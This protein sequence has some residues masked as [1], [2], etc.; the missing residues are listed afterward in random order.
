MSKKTVFLV[1]KLALAAAFGLA[2]AFTL[3]C[4][5]DDNGGSDTHVVRKEKISGVSQKGPFIKGA[6]V[7]IYELDEKKNKTKNSFPGE[8]SEDGKFE[9]K[10][11]GGTLASPYIL[12]EVSGNYVSEVSGN[13]SNTLLYAVAD[14]SDKDNVNINVFTHLEYKVLDLASATQF[15]DAKKAAQK[16]VLKAL[17]INEVGVKNSEDMALFGDSP[18]DS[19]LL[20]ASILLQSAA[21]DVSDLLA[22]IGKEI[23]DNG[24]LSAPTKFAVANGVANL[25][26]NDVANNIRNLNPNA[27]V[28]SPEDI[29][30]I[31]E[32]INNP[33]SSGDVS[34]CISSKYPVCGE[35][36]P[37]A[38][39]HEE[40]DIFGTTACEESYTYCLSLENNLITCTLFGS[41]GKAS[42]SADL[43]GIKRFTTEALCGGSKGSCSIQSGYDQSFKLCVDVNSSGLCDLY[44]YDDEVATFQAG[45]CGT[46]QYPCCLMDGE[47]EYFAN[48]F[49]KNN[50][51][52]IGGMPAN[53]MIC[54]AFGN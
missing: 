5:G 31:V 13:Q 45:E 40:G 50:C 3:S 6:T 33:S 28:P 24:T 2:L 23:K 4:S 12:L 51:Y 8:I 43:N 17:G 26:M 10:I 53:A 20:V 52:S 42:C 34:S 21:E 39:C 44:E 36:I 7:I 27:K 18:S 32:G 14:V 16:K 48:S 37:Q 15:S 11:N 35:N 41:A 38:E 19:I 22:T 30:K 46:E 49:T 47:V 25:D 9:I 29:N 54:K 1:S